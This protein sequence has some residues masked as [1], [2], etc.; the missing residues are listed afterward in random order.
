MG[1]HDFVKWGV[2][3]GDNLLRGRT[4]SRGEDRGIREET[5]PAVCVCVCVLG[6]RGGFWRGEGGGKSGR[7]TSHQQRANTNLVSASDGV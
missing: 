6:W 3:L 5:K 4:E 2:K 7:L 1:V